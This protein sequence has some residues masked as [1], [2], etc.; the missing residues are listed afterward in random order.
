MLTKT[1]AAI[2]LVLVAMIL[3]GFVAWPGATAATERSA[4][5]YQGSQPWSFGMIGDTQWTVKDD[6]YNPNTVAANI[7]KQVD[8]QFIAAGV[9]FVVAVGD[10]VDVNSKVN[11]DTRALYAQSLYNAGI[12][13]YPLRGNHEAAE[14]PNYLDSG[15]ELR[16]AF[17][18]IGAGVNNHTPAAITT[19][20]I[21]PTDL[22][23]NP[24]AAR[25]G[26]TFTVGSNF[27]EPAAVNTANNSVSYAFQYNNAT[28]MLL[29]QFD[30]NGNYYNSTLPQQHSGSAAPWPA[31]R[32]T[33]TPSSSPTRTCSA[34]TTKTTSLAPR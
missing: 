3:I 33:R 19:A 18:Q 30:V 6:G 13:F 15:P 22:L 25:M 32:P 34:A 17:P 2:R 10:T 28:F 1:K 16:Y 23:N 5:G 27:S 8:Q 21:T 24:P 7:I 20:I 26:V 14:D 31:G 4:S 29:D 9:K 12:G 11:I